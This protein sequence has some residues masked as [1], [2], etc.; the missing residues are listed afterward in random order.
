MPIVPLRMPAPESTPLTP[1]ELLLVEKLR[2]KYA[3]SGQ[4]LASYLEGLLHARYLTYWDYLHLDTLLSLQQTR[5]DFPD[6]TIFIV[7]HQITELYFKLIQLELAQLLE[8]AP[9]ASNWQLRLRR[10]VAYF[11]QLTTSFDTMVEG[12]DPTQF[13]HF[14]MALLPASG[15]Q[16]VQFREIEFKLTTLQQLA[17][18]LTG[19]NGTHTLDSLYPHVY[20]KLGNREATTG[21]KTLTLRMFEQHYDADLLALAKAY[22]TRN[23]W[24]QWQANE[25]VRT[26][27]NAQLLRRLDLQANVFWRL[28]HYKSAVRYLQKDPEVIKATGGTNWQQY[29]PPRFQKV[30]YFPGLWTRDELENWG[31]DW[32]VQLFKEQVEENWG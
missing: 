11:R 14:R 7:Y 27:E 10:L 3:H 18:G 31:R 22:N 20:W 6:E 24:V 15:F 25:A 30:V 13:L 4:D 12:M 26:E 29:L 5:T 28:A 2:T 23:L 21:E 8:A 19:A 1:D 32:V 16:S 9:D 17:H